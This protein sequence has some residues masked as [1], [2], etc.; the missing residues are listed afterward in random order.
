MNAQH[1]IQNTNCQRIVVKYALY[2]VVHT[3]NMDEGRPIL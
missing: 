1:I 2:A 3:Y